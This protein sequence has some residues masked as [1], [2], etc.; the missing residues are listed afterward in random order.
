MSILAVLEPR[1]GQW[2]RMSFE[3]LAAAR[4]IARELGVPCEAA[5]V[6]REVGALA[7]GTAAAG[8]A[9]VYAVEHEL[10]EPYTADGYSL[11][12][13]QLVERV[14]PRLVLFPHTYQTRD[15][16][17]K[18][19]ASLG[20]LSVSDVVGH[21]AADG[22]ITLIRQVF[23][24]KLHAEL[25]LTGD[26]PH[27][28]SVQAGAYRA[29]AVSE[30]PAP[31]ETFTPQLKPAQIRTRP[32]ERFRESERAVDLGAADRILAVGRGIREAGN[33]P[34]MQRLATALGA[35]LAASRP[36]C[37]AG[38]SPWSVRSAVP[39]KPW[40]PNSMWP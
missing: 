1:A 39:A 4:A 8:V 25:R 15:F 31:V 2:N 3:T 12:L 28:A 14:R 40:P 32:L 7:A 9:R 5:V 35:E 23:Q 19:A 17:P 34:L 13:R 36:I 38:C 20:R 26:G 29:E 37:D 18:L 6:G 10:L 27:F 33:I 21:R 11:A 16:M 22:G 24:G 30:A